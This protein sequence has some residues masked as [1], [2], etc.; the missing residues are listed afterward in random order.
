M[1]VASGEYGS[2]VEKLS[3]AVKENGEEPFSAS[4]L[5]NQHKTK[6]NQVRRTYDC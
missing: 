6:K 3:E 5:A 4:N 1:E 2:Y